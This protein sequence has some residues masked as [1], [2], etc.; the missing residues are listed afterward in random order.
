MP[1]I[2]N[3]QVLDVMNA[4]TEDRHPAALSSRT[5]SYAEPENVDQVQIGNEVFDLEDVDENVPGLE[6]EG[7][8]PAASW[9]GLKSFKL[10]E[11]DAQAQYQA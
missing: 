5:T 4:P 3:Q 7:Y 6:T 9:E 10:S 2:E 11:W 8:I 1:A